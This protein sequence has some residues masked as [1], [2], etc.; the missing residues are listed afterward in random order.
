MYKVQNNTFAIRVVKTSSLLFTT[1]S[2]VEWNIWR[3]N[4]D[5]TLH[6]YVSVFLTEKFD[7][8]TTS[9]KS[10]V[11]YLRNTKTKTLQNG[12]KQGNIRELVQ[13]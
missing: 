2:I 8:R 11:M 1:V 7:N 13:A 9:Q 6:H 10:S 5:V 12:E 4:Y 3:G